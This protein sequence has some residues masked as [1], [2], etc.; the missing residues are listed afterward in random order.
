MCMLANAH[1]Y[2]HMHTQAH[3]HAHANTHTQDTHNTHLWLKGNFLVPRN[4]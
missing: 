4:P 3:K 1:T 2:T